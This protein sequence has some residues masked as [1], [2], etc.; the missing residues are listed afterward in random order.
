MVEIGA[1]SEGFLGYPLKRLENGYV[2]PNVS[3]S[4]IHTYQQDQIEEQIEFSVHAEE[5]GYDFVTHPENHLSPMA[6]NSPTPLQLQ[7]VVA[8]RTEQIRLVQMAN[9]LPWQDPIR[10]SEKIGML[11]QISDGRVEVGIAPGSGT[12]EASTFSQ[13]LDKIPEDRGGVEDV[14]QE[15]YQILINTWTEDPFSHHGERYDIPPENTEWKSAQEYYYLSDDVSE[16]DPLNYFDVNSEK[17]NL[18]S[19]SVYPQPKQTPRPQIWRAVS[20]AES[21]RWA[22]QNGANACTISSSFED[23]EDLI[24][25]YYEAAEESGWPDHRPEYDGDPFKYGWDEQRSRGL[26][27]QVPVFNTSIS[28]DEEFENWKL[29]YECLLAFLRSNRPHAA[30]GGSTINTKE[31]V[32]KIVTERDFPIVGKTEHIVERVER[33]KETCG[34]DD[35]VIVPVVGLPGMQQEEKLKQLES[36]AVDV[37]PQI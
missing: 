16:A 26:A 15:K 5:L 8:D 37:V 18:K 35:F 20:S 1:H 25:A 11:D 22:A 17:L 24:D 10:L 27:V 30:A 2:V 29:G 12:R 23:V 32:Q 31:E 4:E 7:T 13:F 21:A 6:K 28:T 33:F 9:V 34:Y 3:T 14:F 19:I 36:F